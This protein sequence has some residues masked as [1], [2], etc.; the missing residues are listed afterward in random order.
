MGTE[1][2]LKVIDVLHKNGYELAF[3]KYDAIAYQ[4]NIIVD[5]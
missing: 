4:R 5:L 1:Q 2:F 3:E